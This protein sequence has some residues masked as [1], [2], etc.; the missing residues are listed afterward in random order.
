[1]PK[2]TLDCLTTEGV[3]APIRITADTYEQAAE[4]VMKTPT[5]VEV[6]G[7]Y[8][9]SKDPKTTMSRKVYPYTLKNTN[10]NLVKIF[11]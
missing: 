2:F 4:K 7:E 10:G 9:M 6:K 5:V 3:Y 8:D 11:S 1:M